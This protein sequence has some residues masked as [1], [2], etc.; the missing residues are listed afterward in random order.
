[1]N[2]LPV[3]VLGATGAVGQRFIQLLLDHPWFEVAEVIGSERTA[4]RLYGEAAHWVLDGEIPESVRDLRVKAL[5]EDFDS[6]LVFSALPKEAAEPREMELAAAGHVVCSNAA[7]NRMIEDVPLLLPEVNADHVHLVD[8]QRA[9][10]GWTTGA[11]ITNSNCTTMPGVMA[12]APLRPFGIEGVSIV[13]MQAVSGGGYPGVSSLDILDNIVPYIGG[14][15]HK[16]ETE[17]R[18]ML[19]AL[20]ADSI[21]WLDA[22]VGASCNRVPV[23]DGHLVNIAVSLRERPSLEDI[24]AAWEG[25]IGPAPVPSLP[26]AP[27]QPVQYLHQPDRPQVRRDRAAGNGMTTSVGRLRADP[28]LGYKFVALSHNTV[29]GAAGCSILNAELLAVRGYIDGFESEQANELAAARS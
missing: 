24:I 19:G 15:E 16:V 1:M 10:R 12:L 26:S 23:V 22:Q 20:N 25:F 9:R 11:L 27:K 5:D 3:A 8:V 29:R 4:G 2:K 14:E 13:S 17:T 21:E 6:P 28:V 7:T 18:R